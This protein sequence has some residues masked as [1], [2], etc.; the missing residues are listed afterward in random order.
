ML[1]NRVLP[2]ELR[3]PDAIYP[4]AITF[5]KLLSSQKNSLHVAGFG[6]YLELLIFSQHTKMPVTFSYSKISIVTPTL[7]T[8]LQF[9]RIYGASACMWLVDFPELWVMLKTRGTASQ[10]G[11][12]NME[13][14]SRGTTMFSLKKKLI[15]W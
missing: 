10:P 6:S 1:P 11:A 12:E 8:D 15:V 9:Q 14:Q 3:L 7:A 2:R 4:S 5:L 13:L